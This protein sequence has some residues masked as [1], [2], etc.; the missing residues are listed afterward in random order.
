MAGLNSSLKDRRQIL[1]NWLAEREFSGDVALISPA[2]SFA[3]PEEDYDLAIGS[4][5]AD[6]AGSAVFHLWN[7]LGG[8]DGGLASSWGQGPAR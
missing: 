1:D 6:S 8:G 7:E 3:V 5:Q 2:R 4:R